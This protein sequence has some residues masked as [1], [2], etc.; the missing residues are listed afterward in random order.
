MIECPIDVRSLTRSY[1]AMKALDNVTLAIQRGAVYGLVGPNGSGKTTL[2]RTLCGL[3]KPTAGTAHVLGFDVTTQGKEIRQRVG[4]MS[5]RFSLYDE[6]TA[7]ENLEFFAGLY[8]FSREH[9]DE[10]IETVV[11]LTN[12]RPH[13]DKRAAHLSGGWRQRLALGTALL[14]TP[15]LMFLDEPT[16]GIDPVARRDL[17]DLL[18][19]LAADGMTLLVTT[20]YLDEVERCSDVGYLYLSH[21]IASGT[22]DELKAH[23]VVA[24]PDIRHLEIDCTKPGMVARKLRAQPFCRGA[25][26]FGH[27][28]HAIVE[29]SIPN[30]E[31]SAHIRNWD[32]GRADVRDTT[33]TLEDVFVA[34]THSAAAAAAADSRP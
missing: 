28:V 12:I 19:E 25:T 23:P 15:P 17:W 21:L 16:A 10:R 14:N 20:Q 29:R 26:V 18:F 6:L 24:A 11:A 1:G 31:V 34:L 32:I 4:Y 8:G 33:P 3:L 5:Q 27:C 13:L 30:E 7:R 9:R 2:L 22:P